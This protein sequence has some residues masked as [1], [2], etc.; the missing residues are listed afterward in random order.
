MI[1]ALSVSTALILGLL[2]S[3]HC[4]GM[5]G[6]IAASI[7]LGNASGGFSYLFSYNIG[8]L[9]SYFIA[10]CI[11]GSV[12]AFS[13]DS[14][15]S[16][17][18]RTLAGAMLIAMGL[19]VAQWW[20]GLVHVERLG[21]KLW[22]FIQPA[23]SK[24][25]PV[26]NQKQALSLGFIWGWLPCGLVYSTLIWSATA[27]NALYSGTLML[28]FGV[29]TL[30]AMLA[31]GAFATQVKSLLKNRHFQSVSGGLIILFGIYTIPLR[32]LFA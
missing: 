32:A 16:I 7:S 29:G 5:C 12:G 20:R 10:G 15:L 2:G 13:T 1:E 14:T 9:F 26:R 25:L 30:P 19:Y 21:S 22:S 24:L 27:Q 31:T 11:V 6:G 3:A 23:A 17:I 8:R 18:L 28:A 4:L